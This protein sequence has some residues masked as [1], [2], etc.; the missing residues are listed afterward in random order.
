[1]TDV[2]M[3]EDLP[4]RLKMTCEE[5]A[6]AAQA[7]RAFKDTASVEC[8]FST[9][10]FRAGWIAHMRRGGPWKR[11][12]AANAKTAIS[13]LGLD[14]NNEAYVDAFMQGYAARQEY[15]MVGG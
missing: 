5:F 6:M 3:G 7:A 13:N 14:S 1:M 8:V 9:L 2:I 12:L 15:L 11:S 10:C 4:T